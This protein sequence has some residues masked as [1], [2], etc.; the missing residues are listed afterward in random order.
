MK[1]VI[2]GAGIGGLTAALGLSRAG[3]DVHVLESVP[4]P[5]AL[6]V[7]INLQPNAVRELSELGLAD[8]LARTGVATGTLSMYTKHGQ[9]I[10]SEPR[11]VAAGYRWPQ[12]SIHRGLLLMLLLD[13]ARRELGEDRIRTG[14]HV[15]AFDQ[16]ADGVTAHFRDRRTGTGH[17]SERADVLIGADGIHSTVRA[18]LYPDEGEP[19]FGGQLMW[20]GAVAT[21]PFLDGRT[22]AICGHRDHKFLAYSIR[23][24]D[25]GPLV[26]WVA[27][28]SVP[29]GTP[30]RTDWNRRVAKSTFAPQFTAWRFPWLDVPSLI[31][32]TEAV[33]EFPKVDREPIPQWSFE[34][35]TLLGD[36]AHPMT[37]HGSQAGSQ[38]IA[39]AAVLTRALATE[40]TVLAALRRYEDERLPAMR[41]VTLSNRR[42]GP[43]AAMQIV[44]ERAP[45]GFEKIEDVISHDEMQELTASFSRIAGLDAETVNAATPT[46]DRGS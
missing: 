18:A 4:D 20:R 38:A 34:R 21:E 15:V 14:H 33:Y 37:P 30:P 36:A 19:A 11:G 24:G 22:M 41:D 31:A 45:D 46:A 40:D 25:G 39:D 1:A 8:E 26:N 27:E 44:E 3:I 5:R 23:D 17:G 10:W 43:E 35:V 13:T 9:L 29:G 16:D 7:G 12:Y 6:G 28:L 2:V 32:A 42:L